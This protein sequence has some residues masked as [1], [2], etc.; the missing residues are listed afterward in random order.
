[1]STHNICFYGELTKNYPSIIIK[2]PPHLFFY[3][4]ICLYICYIFCFCFCVTI[5]YNVLI[6]SLV[7]YN[8]LITS[9]ITMF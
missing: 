9:L 3:L 7:D 2:N 1:M 6:T 5:D 4:F 8:V